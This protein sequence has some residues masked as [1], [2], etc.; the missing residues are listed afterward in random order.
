MQY[1]NQVSFQIR[2][3]YALFSDP[4]TRAGGEKCSLQVPTYQALKGVAESIYWKPSF[5]WVI[6]A[7]RVVNTIQ[8]QS[9]GIRPIKYQNSE[10]EL[11][12]YTYLKDV[13][14]QVQA[15]FVWNEQRP[16]LA[17]D[18]NEHK[19][20][21]IA[22]RMIER[23]GRRDVFLGT[24]ECQAYVEPCVFGEGD[25]A[26]DDL[27]ELAFGLT[28]HGLT[29]PDENAKS[30]LMVRFW[31]PV[32]CRGVIAFCPPQECPVQ[33]VIRKDAVKTFAIGENYRM[34]EV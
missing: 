20:F 23:G 10:N 30:Q 15:H 7:V 27:E 21:Q 9:K 4:V 17:P 33:R 18:H 29:Y 19:H 32:M 24:R 11:S 22:N 5:I 14:Y 12:I 16:D 2:G 13:S 34:E 28:Y 26:Y 1:Q 8:T 31:Q 6:D 3:R 25:G